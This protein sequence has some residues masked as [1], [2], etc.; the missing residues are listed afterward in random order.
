MKFIP[1]S[2]IL[3]LNLALNFRRLH[4]NSLE[5]TPDYFNK[6]IIKCIDCAFFAIYILKDPIDK[7]FKNSFMNNK[8]YI[9]G[10]HLLTNCNS[11]FTGC[12][13]QTTQI[14]DLILKNFK[15]GRDVKAT[16]VYYLQHPANFSF[17]C[18]HIQ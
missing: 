1:L 11:T 6:I 4:I 2:Q 12:T 16:L 10:T 18:D 9:P 13:R 8:E 3:F 14:C 15:L 5:C 7:L 17:A